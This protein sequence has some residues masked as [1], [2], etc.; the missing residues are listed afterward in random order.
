MTPLS[1]EIKI[2]VGLILAGLLAIGS[3]HLGGLAPKAA[4]ASYK[5]T[6][7]TALAQAYATQQK[8]TEAKQAAYEQEINYL[9]ASTLTAF[10]TMPVRL[11][12]AASHPVVPQ[13]AGRGQVLPA[14]SGVG[15]TDP[16][17]VPQSAGP[18]YGQELFGLADKFD[19][20]VAN[21]R[22]M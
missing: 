10:P 12:T 20:I 11:C 18:D 21:C 15:K 22:S 13:A 3:Y 4:L 8:A 1:L 6:Q 5:A 2:A 7:A 9:K 17:R 16:E 14:T 19:T